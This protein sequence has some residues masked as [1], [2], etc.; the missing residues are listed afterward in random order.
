MVTSVTSVRLDT[1][2]TLCVNCVAAVRW[3]LC[4]QDVMS[5]VSVC[6]DQSS[7]ALVVTSASLDSTPTPTVKNAPVTNAPR[8]MPAA[9]CRGSAAAGPTTVAR[10]VTSVPPVTTV[11]P[12]AHHA[13]VHQKALATWAVT[14]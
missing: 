8:W 12:A 9:P 11:T 10:H 1:S 4:Q 3:A 7:P 14:S 5:Q 6:A 13:S 2:I